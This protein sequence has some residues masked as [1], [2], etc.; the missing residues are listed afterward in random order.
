M[1]ELLDVA[2]VGGG[3]AG[4]TAA[5]AVERAGLSA[6]VFEAAPRLRAGGGALLL[7]SNGLHALRPLGLADAVLGAGF[8]QERTDFR[9]W[10]GR[11][12]GTL[13]VGEMSRRAGAPSILIQRADLLAVLLAAVG[14][15]AVAFDH[16]CTG[17]VD[18][19][20]GVQVFFA[21]GRS[22]R[23][24]CLVG[25]DGLGSI[26]RRR[27]V[28]DDPP[29]DAHVHAWGG[30]VHLGR[31]LFRAGV[32]FSTIGRGRRVCVAPCSDGALY[33]YATACNTPSG[34]SCDRIDRRALLARFG[35]CH[36]PVPGL[37]AATPED[38][39]FETRV[40]DRPPAEVWG[41]GRV[42]LLGDAVHPATPDL[43]QGAC[44]AMEG[45]VILA[46][47]LAEDGDVEGA[48]R[49]YEAQRKLRAAWVTNLSWIAT[50]QSMRAHPL[51]CLA[52]DFATGAFLE[53]VARAELWKLMS[54]EA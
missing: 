41:R 54:G 50:T 27:L 45:A 29:R 31:D 23:A 51:F 49:R 28:G 16:P 13:P 35:D 22:V 37:I 17:F 47:A 6:R 8:S 40:R 2:I 44:Q 42:T 34:L 3:I 11:L 39:M 12:L 30:T 25:A 32:G 19:R 43:A 33:W 4:L 26:V 52:R 24:R 36:A 53:H 48:L 5:V 46:R 18:E 1:S 38:T 21:G 9:S 20:A 10:S 14:R 15:S 7:W